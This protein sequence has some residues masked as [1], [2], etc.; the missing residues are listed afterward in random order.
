M[1]AVRSEIHVVLTTQLSSL[2][3]PAKYS[4]PLTLCSVVAQWVECRTRN[5]EFESRFATVS[6]FGHFRYLHD[7]SVDSAV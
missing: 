4:R 3:H 1:V 6:K 7:A 2:S 5:R